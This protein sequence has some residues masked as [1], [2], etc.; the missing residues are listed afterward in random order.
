MQVL[1]EL[2]VSCRN[3]SRFVL[4]ENMNAYAQKKIGTY[5]KHELFHR[6]YNDAAMLAKNCELVLHQKKVEWNIL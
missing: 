1:T 3:V 6:Y 5:I 4:F 2:M